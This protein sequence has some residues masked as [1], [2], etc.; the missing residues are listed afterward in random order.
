[1]AYTSNTQ[2][3]NINSF[4]TVVNATV[5]NE[6]AQLLQWLSP[7]EPRQ[8]HK[9]LRES[10]LDGVGQW[11]FQT[12]ELQR[13]NTVEDGSAHSVLFCHGDPGVG[14]THL[15][16]LVID[17]FQGSGQ[18]ITVTA[19]YCDY[20]DKKEQTT[21]NMIGAILKQ[22]V[23]DGN[24]PEDICK[25]FEV[26]KR[27]LGGVGP[28][29][30]ELLKMLKT[31]L[32]QRQRVVICVDGLDESLPDHRTGLLKALR[33]IIQEL[34]NVRLFLTARP[35]ILD[36]IKRYF[37]D[38]DTI[39]VTPSKD[40]VK[41]L[42]KTKLEE[43]TEPDAMD[44]HLRAQIMETIPEKVSEIFLLV[45][46]TIEA[47][48]GETTIHRRKEKL[49]QMT[50]GRDVGDVYTA[51]LDRIKAQKKDRA[52]LGLEA[53]MWISHSEWSL[54]PEVL[55]QALGV[56]PGLED[57]NN[58]N[59][60]TIRTILS[61][62]LGL[63]TLD[64]S[65]ATV[66]LV[67]FTL[68]EYILANPTLFHSPHSMIAEVCLTYLNYQSIRDLS[69][70]LSSSPPTTPFLRYASC[71]WG[72]HARRE[73]TQGVKELAIRLL[74]QFDTHV[75]C[76]LLWNQSRYYRTMLL[77][78]QDSPLE[79]TGL[80]AAAVFGVQEIMIALLEN[81]DWDLNATD[82]FGN[83]VLSWAARKGHEGIMK[84]LL[85]R[86]DVDS[87]RA[88]YRGRTPF[89]WAAENGFEGIVELL[90]E[91]NDVDPDRA[92]NEGRTPFLFAA[93]RGHVHIVKLLEERRNLI[94]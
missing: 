19:L 37:T 39:S 6:K 21:S 60:P 28:Q 87:D 69:P 36:E 45:S 62:G 76:K 56:Q 81:K 26:G 72:A 35:F 74:E 43:D 47:I 78:E 66:R 73:T 4:N 92:D 42:L 75:A 94:A 90:L 16:S 33:E 85:E 31:V 58:E 11:I 34:P 57:L 20:L 93:E 24:I 38:I 88:D 91:R 51:T 25:A 29:T 27:Y 14:K 65:S 80:H 77:D 23:G 44:D 30:S 53:I 54:R 84:M 5:E 71:N 63:I 67:H 64:S 18:D 9:H 79:F 89:S 50:N 52:R 15:S 41:I 70:T 12:R 59:Q 40:D 86:S 55:C 2:S 82:I 13:W 7:L 46:L 22:M 61:C 10:R 49:K 17:H 68:Q 48:L 3:F 83:T 1:M 32:A 8:R